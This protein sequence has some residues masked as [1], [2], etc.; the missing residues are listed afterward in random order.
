MG[1]SH[2]GKGIRNLPAHG[3]G[4]CPVC[5]ST[6]IKLLYDRPGSDGKPVKVCK[7]CRHKTLP[8]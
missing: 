2:R 5:Q 1:K 8:V 4:T 3:R 7:R 6:R